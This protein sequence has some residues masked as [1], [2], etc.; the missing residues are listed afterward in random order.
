M[1]AILI[2]PEKQT[3]TEVNLKGDDYREINA[4]LRCHSHTTGAHLSGSIETGFEAVYVSDDEFEDRDDPRF[5]F[6]V[7]ADRDPP[8][9]Y[10][11][12]GLG[13]ALGIDTE[14]AGCDV[15][16][17]IEELT[18]RITFTQRKFRSFVTST[19]RGKISDHEIEVFRVDLKAPIIDGTDEK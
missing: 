9:S 13:L 15:K 18:K 10:P 3:L 1:R 11:I 19:G 2:D 7:D 8:S 17:S 5:W 16:I 6:Q 4:V 14:G 12:A